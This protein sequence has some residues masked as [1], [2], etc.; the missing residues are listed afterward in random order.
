MTTAHNTSACPVLTGPNNF[1]IWKLRII[2][3]LRREKVLRVVTGEELK[4]SPGKPTSSEDP[5]I[6]WILKDEK[7][8]GIIQD[9]ISDVGIGTVILQATVGK[10]DYNIALSNV[11]LVPN[12][13]LALVSVH[14]LSKMG[15]STLFPAGSNACEVRKKEELILTALHKRGLYHIQA[16]PKINLESAFAAVDTAPG[17][18]HPYRNPGVL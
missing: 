14:K 6:T 7:A 17:Q 3:K 10:K 4:P 13:M 18:Q 1:Q 11:L 16:K 9:H 12:F 15:L 2:S 5:E 8:H